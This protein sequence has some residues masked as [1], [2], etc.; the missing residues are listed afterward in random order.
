MITINNTTI[1]NGKC[2]IIAEIAS[3]HC[4]SME[5][6]KNIIKN[7]AD[8]GGDAVKVQIFSVDHFVSTF[9]PNYPNNKKNE[10]SQAQWKEILT[11][12]KQF[13]M[14]LWADVFDEQSADL[15]E[16]YVEGFKLHS[17]DI[18]NPFMIEHVAKKDKPL[19]VAVGGSTLEEVRRAVKII[20]DQGNTQIILMHGFQDFPTDIDKVHLRKMEILRKEFPDY[21]LGY[22]DHTDAEKEMA[23]LLPVTA[24]SYGATVIEKH[25]T[26]DRVAKGFDY[27][28]SLNPDELTKMVTLIRDFEKTLGDNSFTMSEVELN[29]RKTM[30]R[31]VVAKKPITKGE[32][33]T[34]EH[35]AFKRSTQGIGP[36]E[37][38]K[39]LQCKAARDITVDE[40]ILPKDVENKTVI[41]MAVRLKSTRL[42]RKALLDIEGQTAI[43]HQIDRLRQCKNGELVLCTSTLEEDAPLIEVAKKKGIKYFAGDPDDVMDRFLKCAEREGANI[44]VRT[45]GDC[46]LLDP[47]IIDQQIQFHIQENADYTGVEEVPIGLEAEVVHV[48]TLKEARSRVKDAKDTEYMTWFIKDPRHFNVMIMPISNEI[49][50]KYRITLDITEDLEVIQRIYKALYHHNKMFSTEE[51]VAFLDAHPEIVQIN[52]NYKQIR[53]V[54]P[55]SEIMKL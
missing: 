48:R 36:N 20:E 45:T 21:I 7:C 16:H 54:P 40:S 14:H 3:A 50:R 9:H 2:Y 55:L 49:K 1:G 47:G 19:I 26:D 11:Y 35:L 53:K 39:I 44:I 42:P 12:A 51:V 8:S 33:I 31:Y 4:G 29:Y 41:C 34:R 23:L 46:P 22:H 37:V 18:N 27:M 25:V 30:K 13:N 17:T 43:E 6:M 5:K 52:A 32:V 15:A 24:F 10:F 28:S 38:E